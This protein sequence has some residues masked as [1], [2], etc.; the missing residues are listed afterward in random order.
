M[1]RDPI[2]LRARSYDDVSAGM[3]ARALVAPPEPPPPELL[4]CPHCGERAPMARARAF[5][6]VTSTDQ[7]WWSSKDCLVRAARAAPSQGQPVPVLS[8]DAP[9]YAQPSWTDAPIPQPGDLPGAGQRRE[10][11]VTCAADPRHSMLIAQQ[12][13]PDGTTWGP[14][15]ARLLVAGGWLERGPG[16]RFC[17]ASCAGSVRPALPPVQAVE[18]LN[19]AS[20]Q[21]R[22]RQLP[23]TPVTRELAGR[24]V[25]DR[26]AR[27]KASR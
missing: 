4:T 26:P 18:H 27:V 5:G 22:A 23:P 13:Q 20:W 11:R 10:L 24:E 1:P 2:V 8:A 3:T 25:P 15:V 6:W 7:R 19:D 9:P 17:S 16:Q 12:L 14:D 21:P